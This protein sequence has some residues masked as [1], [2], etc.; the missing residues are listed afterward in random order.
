MIDPERM[1][2]MAPDGTKPRELLK[3]KDWMREFDA[4]LK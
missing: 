4:S 1:H 2:A 3:K